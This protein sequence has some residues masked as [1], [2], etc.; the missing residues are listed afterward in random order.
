MGDTDNTGEY[1]AYGSNYLRTYVI[2]GVNL[3]LWQFSF[4]LEGNVGAQIVHNGD[5]NF[6]SN[7]RVT[8]SV[9]FNFN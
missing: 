9:G 3:Q 6:A 1:K 8:A 5:V 4:F 7:Y 2:G